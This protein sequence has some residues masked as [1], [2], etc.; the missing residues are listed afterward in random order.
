MESAANNKESVMKKPKRRALKITLWVLAL[1]LL[2]LIVGVAVIVPAYMSSGSFRGMIIAKANAASGGELGIADLS[3]S[4]GRGINISG[5]SFKDKTDSLSVAVRGFSTKPKYG[6][7]L[8]GN[9]A[10][11]E[12]IID[13]PRVEIDVE[14][15]YVDGGAGS[16]RHGQKTKAGPPM[17]SM[18]YGIGQI[19]LVVKSGDV[20]I[21][22]GQETMEVSQINS[23]VNLRGEGQKSEFE[24]GANIVGS[25]EE[26]TISAKGGITPGKNWDMKRTSAEV[27]IEA[28]NLSLGQLESLLA[29][30]GIDVNAKGVVS[31]NIKGAMKNGT[32]ENIDA[33]VVGRGF[34][35][36]SPQLKGDTIKTN[37][38]D[39]T[40]KLGQQDNLINVETMTCRTD[41][42]QIDANGIVPMSIA[43]MDDFLKPDSKNELKATLECD[44][45]AIA[46]QLPK[47]LALKEGMKITG[48]RI[49]A[50]AETLSDA[51]KKKLSGEA[52]IEGLSGIMDGKPITISAPIRAEALVT[53]DEKEIKFEKAEVTSAFAKVSC[54][55]TTEAF[56]YTAEADLAKLSSELGKFADI[57]KY[58]LG[59]QVAGKGQIS[60]SKSTTMIVA[61]SNITNLK[62]SPTADIV[63]TEPNAEIDVTAA[64]DKQK[65]LLL[66]KEMKADTSLGQY[67]VKDGRLPMGKDSKEAMEL[68]ATARDVDLSRLQPYLV[69]AK[70][71]SKD[72]QLGGVAES[73]FTISSKDGVY[74]ITTESTKVTNLFVKAPGKQPF[75][76]SPIT[77][78][79]DAELNPTTGAEIIKVNIA[80][81]DI[82]TIQINIKQ[83][84]EGQMRNLQGSAQ[85]D[86]D[87]KAISGILSAF[88]PSG[89]T[90][91]GK[92]KDTISFSSRYPAGDSNAMLA[93]LDA[94]AKV[95]FNRASYMGLNIGSTNVDIKA[96]KGLL[97]IKPFTTTV[98]TGEFNFGGSAD[99]KKK[100]AIFRTPG[101]MQIVKNVQLNDEMAN[102]L[103]ARVNPMFSG[104][105][106][107]NGVVDF[108]CESLA[109][110]IT[111][112]RPEDIQA[113]GTISMPRLN[114]R[115]VGILGL[116]FEAAGVRGQAEMAIRPTNF[117]IKDG[118][119]K[120]LNDM[121]LDIGKTPVIFS[122]GLPL[123]ST[124]QIERFDVTLPASVSG[125][126]FKIT[127]PMKGTPDRPEIDFGKMIQKLL[128]EQTIQILLE[129]ATK[130]K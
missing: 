61:K 36:T 125:K 34:E 98:N 83:E 105:I 104:A 35:I 85:L 110:P 84:A 29:I 58:K 108:N 99:F 118:F 101:P 119:V 93:N 30:A 66:V 78:E 111:G 22:R 76:Q 2:I 18:P 74:K 69:M 82:K 31:A 63:V 20:K 25:G 33:E 75:T 89:L 23:S 95:G 41:W 40:A 27:T 15:V 7:L 39:I 42:L 50:R 122:G 73:D 1:L 121:Q 46:G 17:R 47:T 12:T 8:T 127:A 97:T 37:V 32:I 55:G 129:K 72:V 5:L 59:G 91:E 71:I 116:I 106:D 94:Q 120:Y 16:P 115:P 87:W 11:G 65:Q 64:I 92:R 43:S 70:T 117:V 124:K 44:V 51:G 90:M 26:S 77:L 128:Q 80:S 88:M 107:T 67:S 14:K 102:K 57:S 96:E 100:P 38:L 79:L 49:T 56:S 112:G 86:Y 113:L 62:V 130:G 19:N 123:D 10:F 53:A 114:M 45:A 24:I 109:A 54:S 21:K 28:N 6:A 103:L 13:E 60:N 68:T 4:W 48:G 81:P 9:L 126:E 52:S 3:M